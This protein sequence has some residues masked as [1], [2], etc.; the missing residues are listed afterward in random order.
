MIYFKDDFGLLRTSPRDL[1]PIDNSQLGEPLS[2]CEDLG[3]C[4]LAGDTRVNEQAA[5][6]AMHTV[7][8]REHNRIATVLRN[9]NRHWDGEK[10]FQ[11]TRNILGAL[12]QQITYEEWLP[13][14]I[15]RNALRR[16]R[17]YRPRVSAGVSN[18]FATAAFRLGHSLVRPKFEFLRRNFVPF[19]FSPIPLRRVFFNNTVTQRFGIDG[20][21][22]G[23]VG[24]DSQE[25][26]NEMA[27]GLTN[28][29]FERE[30]T[31][32]VGLNLAALNMQRGRE[33]GLPSYDKFLAA[34]GRRFRR[35]YPID[36]SNV[37]TFDQIRELFPP[38]TFESIKRAYNNNPRIT[39]VWAAGIGE[40][41]RNRRFR[42][43]NRRPQDNDPD[44]ILGPTFTCLLIDQFERS[45]EGDRFFY[46]NPGVFSR[47]QLQSIRRTSLASI[48]CNNVNI[49]SVPKMIFLYD[50]KYSCSSISR[51]NLQPWQGTFYCNILPST[52]FFHFFIWYI[53]LLYYRIIKCKSILSEKFRSTS[54]GECS[55]NI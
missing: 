44:P 51:M 9:L 35:L 46:R 36:V 3:S 15:G 34:C 7:W 29:L 31:Q 55:E 48:I 45:R 11:E 43:N 5:L 32:R 19:P 50:R 13:I 40:S 49:V 22:V 53:F 42:R 27:I 28:N 37:V 30:D 10:I 23:M 20:W 14:V 6:A 12:V 38:Q 39:D 21:M 1:L 33:H 2:L 4:F 47:E 18:A 25:M 16:Y 54:F 26:D 17:R 8:V 41:P 24:N 52:S